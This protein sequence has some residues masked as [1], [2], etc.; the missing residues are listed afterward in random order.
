ML[1]LDQHFCFAV[2]S[3]AH[4]FNR[5]Y[6]PL[7]DEL[8][9]TY[10]QYLVLVVLWHE[11]EQSVSRLAERL[12]LEPS[13]LTPMLKRLEKTGYVTRTRSSEDERVV[14]VDLAAKGRKAAGKVPS[15]NVAIAEAI[16]ETPEDRKAVQDAL[17]RIRDRLEAATS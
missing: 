15:I 14:T 16:G 2:Y 7:L 17:L 5:L 4:M 10:P 13:T 6:R 9:I 11:G 3:T 1:D 8:G 12:K